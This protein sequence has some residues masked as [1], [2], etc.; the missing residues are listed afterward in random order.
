[1]SDFTVFQVMKANHKVKLLKRS[2]WNAKNKFGGVHIEEEKLAHQSC[3][4]ILI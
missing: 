4:K 1:M 2:S 3:E